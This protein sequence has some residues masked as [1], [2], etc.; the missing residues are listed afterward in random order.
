M[1][2][3]LYDFDSDKCGCN[4]EVEIDY[5][6]DKGDTHYAD[7]RSYVEP[8]VINLYGVRVIVI[9]GYDDEGNVVYRLASDEI[10]ADWR[11]DLDTAALAFIQ[12][13]VDSDCG[14]CDDLME[15]YL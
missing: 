5:E 11:K 9:E 10:P 4:L 13:L 3:L 8:D 12:R 6:I 1:S 7:Y 14:I 15:N 2:I